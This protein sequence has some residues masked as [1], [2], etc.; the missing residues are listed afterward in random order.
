INTSDIF[1]DSLHLKFAS[2]LHSMAHFFSCD[3]GTSSFRLK[4]VEVE[5]LGIVK[6]VSSDQGIA[7]TFNFLKEQGTLNKDEKRKFY[8]NIIHEHIQKIKNS[9]DFSLDGVPL[10]I[11]GMASSSIGIEELPYAGLP[12][13]ADGSNALATYFPEDE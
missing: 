3:W 4:L 8:L 7:A 10:V 5:G 13:K 6:E 9:I 2:K 12:F 11:S 1:L